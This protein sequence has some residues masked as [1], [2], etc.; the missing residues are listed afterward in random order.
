MASVVPMASVV[1]VGRA[2]TGVRRWASVGTPS[3]LFPLVPCS[4]QLAMYSN[5]PIHCVVAPSNGHRGLL[6]TPLKDHDVGFFGVLQGTGGVRSRHVI[7]LR[8]H[9]YPSPFANI[10]TITWCFSPPA[11]QHACVCSVVATRRDVKCQRVASSSC[12]GRSLSSC[13][14]S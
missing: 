6:S 9:G 13:W 12:R 1:S 8:R 11:V 14:N 2:S 7:F 5:D 3:M 4:S 10:I